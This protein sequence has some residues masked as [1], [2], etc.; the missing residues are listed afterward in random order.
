MAVTLTMEQVKQFVQK[1]YQE[2]ENKQVKAQIRNNK[3]YVGYGTGEHLDCITEIKVKG[4]M[5]LLG[6]Q[7]PFEESVSKTKLLK[8]FQEL[9]KRQN[10]E[11]KNLYIDSGIT[12]T[13]V[14]Y[15]K[16][17]H[18]ETK[19][20]CNG[21]KLYLSRKMENELN[22]IK[23]EMEEIYERFKINCFKKLRRIRK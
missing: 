8:I 1:Y 11:V 2:I 7:I 23:T 13:Y 14:G 15:G 16:G 22:R 19:V 20:Y 3:G 10:I 4:F 21:I 5:E 18:K 17:E 12:S 9:F 6:K